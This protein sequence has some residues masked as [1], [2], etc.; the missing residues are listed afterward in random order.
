MDV[1]EKFRLKFR[2]S[3]DLYRC[4]LCEF[5][6]TGLLVF[7]GTTTSAQY[8]LSKG[9]QGSWINVNLGWGFALVMAVYAGYNI[10]G[11]HLNPAVSLFLWTMG[12]LSGVRCILYSIVQILGGFCASFFTWV[13]YYDALNAYDGGT[14][15]VEGELATAGIFSTYPKA[16]LSVGGGIADQVIGTAYLCICVCM[17]TDKRNKIPQH[18]Q[19]LIIGFI[20]V[21]IGICA[22]MNGYAINTARDLGPRLFTLC[23]GWGW[24]TFSYN[25]YKWFWI[26]TFCPL[27]GGVLGAWIYQFFLGI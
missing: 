14:R 5:F 11:S 2:I 24:G 4:L 9:T 16:F 15:M 13:L 17:V 3:N 22:G 1:V 7:G 12:R 18:L 23:A 6:C 21:Q 20:V 19:P 10:S 27:V 8:V 25:N 26:P